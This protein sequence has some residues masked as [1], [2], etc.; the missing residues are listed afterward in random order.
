MRKF[1]SLVLALAMAMSLVVVNTSAAEYEDDSDISYDEAVAVVSA[2]GIVEGDENGNF[3]PTEGLSRRAAAKIICNLILGPTTAAELHAD[4]RPFSDV[5]IDNKFAGYIAYCAQQGI[6]SGYADG[7]FR[8]TAPLTGYAFMKMLLGALGYDQNIEQFVGENWSINVAKQAIGI[9][10]NEGLV[11]E[12]NGVDNVTREEAV[13]YAFNTL[14]ATM[15][16]YDNKIS[17]NVNGAEVVISNNTAKPVDWKEGIN[18]DGN[19]WRD[20]FVQFAEEY[21][22]DLVRHDGD[23]KFMEPANVWTYDKTEIGTYERKDLLVTDPYTTGVSGRDLY[24]LLKSGVIKENDFDA[25]LDGADNEGTGVGE[26]EKDDLVRSNTSDLGSTGNGVLTKVYLDTDKELITLVS[27]NTYL[28][29]ATNDYNEDSEYATLQVYDGITNSKAHTTPYNVDV[30]EVPNVVD[31]TSGSFYAVN[32][33]FRDNPTRGEV[34]VLGD[35][36]ILEDSTISEYSSDDGNDDTHEAK[37]TKLT[38]GGEEYSANEKAFYDDEILYQYNENLLTDNTYNVY[39]DQYGYFLGV[40]LFE[41]TKNYVF[42]TGFDRNSSN[43]AVK[44]ATA[45]AIFLDGTMENIEVNVTATDSNIEDAWDDFENG[46]NN[47]DLY[48]KWSTQG[49]ENREGSGTGAWADLNKYGINGIYNLNQWYTYTVNDAGVYTLKPAVRS[50]VTGYGTLP[51]DPDAEDT[52]IRTDNLS[53]RD[54]EGITGRVYGEDATVFLTVDLD[55]VDTSKGAYAIT[56]VNGVYTGV[57]NVDLIV[58]TEDEEAVV[59]RQVYTVFDSDGYVIAA[60]VIGE[61]QGATGNYAYVLSQAKSEGRDE[62]GTYYWTFEAVLEGEK[63]TLTARG[64]Y[65]STIKQ[66]QKGDVVE[67]RFDGDYV[68]NAKKVPYADMYTYY[69]TDVDGE[70]IY[71]ITSKTLTG[72]SP[73]NTHPTLVN[74]QGNTLYVTDRA[75][76]G[77]G[78]ARDA[79]AVVIQKENGKTE[80]NNFPDVLS[81]FNHLA[82]YNAPNTPDVKDYNGTIMAVL[83]SSGAAEWIVFDS[84][85]ELKT[86]TDTGYGQQGNLTTALA[87]GYSDTTY[88]VDLDGSRANVTFTVNEYGLMS[89]TVDYTAPEWVPAGATVTLSNVPVLYYGATTVNTVTFTGIVGADG[90]ATLYYASS[91]PFEYS[92]FTASA[93]SFGAV[94]AGHETFSEVDVI[95]RDANDLDRDISG[96]LD[97][98]NGDT[99]ATLGT[100]DTLKIKLP[101]TSPSTAQATVDV[102]D[103]STTL[104]AT[105]NPY[106][107]NGANSLSSGYETH[108]TATITSDGPVV[109]TLGLGNLSN[110]YSVTTATGIPAGVFSNTGSA[111]TGVA[112]SSFGADAADNAVLK[113]WTTA[114][115]NNLK[116]YNPVTFQAQITDADAWTAP[117]YDVRLTLSTGAVVVIP[118]VATGGSAKAAA[119]AIRM[120]DGNVTITGITVTPKPALQ[121][122]DVVG[123]GNTITVTFNTEIDAAT[124]SEYVLTPTMTPDTVVFGANHKIVIITLNQNV[125]TVTSL[126]I[127]GVANAL[128][129]SN[130]VTETWN[131]V[132]GDFVDPTP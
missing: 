1:L 46:K 20:G 83:N 8:P 116:E 13:L 73:A 61:A 70:D 6:I 105:G 15:V 80:I 65:D 123:S 41:G 101:N 129:T 126:Q 72:V 45:G 52:V 89:A 71:F 29:K 25:Y 117:A 111:P 107:N 2:I 17:A 14:K 121:V 74:L 113:V 128:N 50:T 3:N 34:V 94:P 7:T 120:P 35:V 93:L 66:M 86:G 122:L 98:T 47:A 22:P 104:T 96:L 12:F 28:A 21:F 54:D 31:V 40:D 11:D 84:N 55:E 63:Q 38:T 59:E 82:D 19:I 36:D 64:D 97:Y 69:G 90:K 67:L 75:D 95:Y 99:S 118:A 110:I 62:D 112:V 16:D 100:G 5:A 37:V 51:V 49:Y 27:I 108:G 48:V 103:G 24:D 81:A 53:V 42:I 88:G 58:N 125:S 56:D 60:V 85:G 68:V 10:L 79:K 32:V 77:L 4:T 78:I 119:D 109:V 130:T 92:P 127:N 30:E 33:S 26:V 9:G 18:E 43:L 102:V 57:Q 115:A 91:T 132:N 44:T 23:T 76:W 131:G 106:L 39:L 124:A 114:A 87:N